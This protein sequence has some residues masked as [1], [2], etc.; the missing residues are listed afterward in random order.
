M[1]ESYGATDSQLDAAVAALLKQI[2]PAK[3]TTT[4]QR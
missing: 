3:R 2:G 4:S 1:G